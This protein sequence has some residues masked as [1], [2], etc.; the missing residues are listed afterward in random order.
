MEKFMRSCLTFINSIQKAKNTLANMI[1]RITV[2]QIIHLLTFT[3][4]KG[5]SRALCIDNA[6]YV[7]SGMLCT[8]HSAVQ[9][10]DDHMSYIWDYYTYSS[11]RLHQTSSQLLPTNGI[12][13]SSIQIRMIQM[14]QDLGKQQKGYELYFIRYN[15]YMKQEH[16][17][18]KTNLW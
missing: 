2:G 12:P 8:Y 9:Y 6:K 10:G 18:K 13:Y 16:V 15:V 1:K 7:T 5:S 14:T 3:L 11:L 4:R 17:F